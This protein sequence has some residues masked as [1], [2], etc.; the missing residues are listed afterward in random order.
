M[1][2]VLGL[3]LLVS[4]E[5]RPVV[6]VLLKEKAMEIS[7]PTPPLLFIPN[8]RLGHSDFFP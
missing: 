7:A 8:H 3:N 1:P 2:G 6:G 5:L 4:E